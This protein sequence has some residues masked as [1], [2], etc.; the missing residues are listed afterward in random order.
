MR[1]KDESSASLLSY[2]DLEARV[3]RSHPLRAIRD[4]TNAAL[5]EMSGE[6]EASVNRALAVMSSMM[7]HAEAPGLLRGDSN[8]DKGLRRRKTGFEVL[9]G[10]TTNSSRSIRRSTGRRQTIR[11]PSQW[12]ACCS[13]PARAG[14]RC[15]GSY[16]SM[17]KGDR[18][19]RANFK[20]D[21][22]TIQLGSLARAVLA[23]RQ[24]LLDAR[25]ARRR[26]CAGGQ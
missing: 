24:L 3:P 5:V 25:I 10:R 16:G 26:A 23:A 15:R 4:L 17:F 20:A 21:S 18:A 13:T 22:R 7:K 9:Y 2:V 12:C 1:G 6:F 19:V 11:S 14:P 8:P